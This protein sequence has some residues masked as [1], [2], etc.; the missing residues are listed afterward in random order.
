MKRNTIAILRGMHSHHVG[1]YFK[2]Y[3]LLKDRKQSELKAEEICITIAD[4]FIPAG[5]SMRQAKVSQE[6][7]AL[8]TALTSLEKHGLLIYEQDRILLHELYVKPITRNETL[9]GALDGAWDDWIEYKE[10]NE[11]YKT[12]KS[13]LIAYNRLMKSLNDNTENAKYCIETA[14]SRQWKGINPE[15]GLVIRKKANENLQYIGRAYNKI[16]ELKAQY[17]TNKIGRINRD[18]LQKWIDED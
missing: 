8:D 12:A 10:H 9:K 5:I 6:A 13:E 17:D 15:I 18:D 3:H 16:N 2:I 11:P 7:I 4:A 1:A 14:I